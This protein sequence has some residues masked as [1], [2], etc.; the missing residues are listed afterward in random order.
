MRTPYGHYPQYHTSADNLDLMSPEALADSLEKYR[1]VVDMPGNK[2]NLS[3][4]QPQVRTA[5]GQA[6]PYI[7]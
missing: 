1:A 4:Y 6:G 2:P 3:Q 5:A 7:G